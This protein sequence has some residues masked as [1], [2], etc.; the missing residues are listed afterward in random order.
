MIN[1]A[2]DEQKS[3]LQ[4]SLTHISGQLISHY[5]PKSPTAESYRS[6]RTNIIANKQPGSMSMLVTSSAPKEGKST[7]SS[8]LAVTLAQMSN[9]VVI[10][11][12]DMRRPT[13]HT[14]F[15]LTKD[16]GSS[17]YL[18][19]DTLSVEDVVKHSGIPNLDVITSGF[20]PPN[21]SELIASARMDQFIRELEDIYDYILFDSP[22]IIAVTDAII[23][24]KKVDKV[25]LVLR[26][27]FTEKAVLAR[28]NEML[29][30]V[31]KKV[32]GFIVNG[33]RIQKY[34]NRHKYY[35]YYYYYYYGQNESKKKSRNIFSFLRKN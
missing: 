4:R 18:I 12:I 3:K 33:I 28:A 8:N 22:P 7:T 27:A 1:H 34:Y 15:G 35:Y 31:D 5:S 30:N 10:V 14:K 20:I 17:D 13:I 32:D 25:L 2:S 19:D 9:K 16:N 26:V 24:S 29:R 21:P 23:M 11:D 6:L